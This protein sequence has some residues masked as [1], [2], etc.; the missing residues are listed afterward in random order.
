MHGQKYEVEQPHQHEA[1]AEERQI[2]FD[3]DRV[4][5]LRIAPADEHERD[6]HRDLQQLERNNRG[7]ARLD[8]IALRDRQQRH[9]IYVA[10]FPRGL[11]HEENTEGVIEKRHVI[12]IARHEH[13]SAQQQKQQRHRRDGQLPFLFH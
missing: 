13:E 8:K 4:I 5:D 3:T 9:I 6:A 11:Q 2:G 7:E 10:V 12:R 1:E